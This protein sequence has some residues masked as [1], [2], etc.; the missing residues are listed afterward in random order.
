M[1]IFFFWGGEGGF[2]VWSILCMGNLKS[3]FWGQIFLFKGILKY[4]KEYFLKT[5]GYFFVWGE[6]SLV[7]ECYRIKLRGIFFK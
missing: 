4:I 2:L 7:F 3:L 1:Q 6:T 5:K